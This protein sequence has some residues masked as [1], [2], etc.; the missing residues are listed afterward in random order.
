MGELRSELSPEGPQ[1]LQKEQQQTAAEGISSGGEE[2][3]EGEEEAPAALMKKW[4]ESGLKFQTPGKVTPR[5]SS[6]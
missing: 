6:I 1:E 5:Q 4:V 2:G 3:E